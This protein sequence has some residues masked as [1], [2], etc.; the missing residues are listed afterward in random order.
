MRS[1]MWV[2]HPTMAI[3]GGYRLVDDVI[4]F[5]GTT[6]DPHEGPVGNGVWAYL[7]WRRDDPRIVWC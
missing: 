1:L 4:V 6:E 7:L 2:K 3:V 5:S